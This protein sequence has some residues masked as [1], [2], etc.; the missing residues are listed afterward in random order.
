M[1]HA[2]K[3]NCFLQYAAT[4]TC[5][6]IIEKQLETS[7]MAC[8]R[9]NP[10]DSCLSNRETEQYYLKLHNK[11]SQAGVRLCMAQWEKKQANGV[12]LHKLRGHSKKASEYFFSTLKAL[13]RHIFP[14]PGVCFTT[15][16]IRNASKCAELY[17]NQCLQ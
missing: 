9:G 4:L 11:A 14:N 17:R 16:K 10:K 5:G 2:L 7:E 13:C 3:S 12:C 1:F 15:M 6:C 8:S